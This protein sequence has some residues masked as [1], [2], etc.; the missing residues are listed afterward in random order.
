MVYTHALKHGLMGVTAKPTL[1]SDSDKGLPGPIT[2]VRNGRNC[3]KVAMAA[4]F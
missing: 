3:P 2:T 4:R 1:C